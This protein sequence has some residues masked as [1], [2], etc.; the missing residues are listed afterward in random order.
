MSRSPGP[1]LADLRADVAARAES[2]EWDGATPEHLVAYHELLHRHVYSTDLALPPTD[3]AKATHAVA[4]FVSEY[5]AGDVGEAARFVWWAWTREKERQVR[6]PDDRT[7]GWRLVFSPS[8]VSDYRVSLVRRGEPIPEQ[9]GPSTENSMPADDTRPTIVVGVDERRVND[10]AIAALAIAGS[11]YD[12]DGELVTV[13]RATTRDKGKVKRAAGTPRLRAVSVA[14]LRE[15]MAAAAA[16]LR[17]DAKGELVACAPPEASVKAVRDRGEWD[18]IRAL[19]GIVECPVLRP[20]GSLLDR[21]GYDDA[22]GLLFVP[23]ADFAAVPTSPTEAEARAAVALLREVVEQFPFKGPE[24]RSV[25]LALVLS[26]FAR[27][28]IDGPVPLIAIDAA[29]PGTGKTKLADAASNIFCGRDAAKMPQPSDETERH[30]TLVSLLLEGARFVVE[31]NVNR[32]LDD[33]ALNAVLTT[34]KYKGRALGRNAMVEVDAL[35]VFA[36]TGN[37]LTIAGDLT[38]R[39]MHCRL[40]SSLENPDERDGFSHPDLLGWIR[41]ERAGRLV[42]AALTLLRAYFAAGRPEVPLAAWGSFESWSNVVRAALVWVGEPDPSLTRQELRATGDVEK[43]ALAALLKQWRQT[44][45]DA[46]ST[47]AA[48]LERVSSAA[49]SSGFTLSPDVTASELGKAIEGFCP[50]QPGKPPN[51]RAVGK[52][53]ASARSRVVAGLAF[54]VRGERRDGLIWVART[55]EQAAGMAGIASFFQEVGGEKREDPACVG[56]QRNPPHPPNPQTGRVLRPRSQ[57]GRQASPTPS[58]TLDFPASGASAP[59]P[60]REESR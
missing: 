8:F 13:V 17:G 23:N 48:A 31:D 25:W 9:P 51:L 39:T 36:A 35:A 14:T 15:H 45:G 21:P 42:P 59:H 2:G 43:L 56:V 11:L 6:R 32:P 5:F 46:G 28:A 58:A 26:L 30:K 47:V 22:T 18:G 27:P 3:R 24:H 29:T 44:F 60:G 37:N 54:D 4:A 7:L 1:Q 49:K 50:S 12:R 38:R 33:A 41:A 55:V 40:E 16:W 20:D 19:A 53:L 10:E 34:T 57:A 52:R